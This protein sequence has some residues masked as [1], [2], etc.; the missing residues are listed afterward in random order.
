MPKDRKLDMIALL[1]AVDHH[2][3]D[4]LA[5]QSDDARKE[6]QPVVALRWAAGVSAG[7]DAGCML[8]LINHRV[9]RHLWAYQEP[10]LSFRLLASC[11]LG[12]SLRHEWLPAGRTG[13]TINAAYRLLAEHHPDANDDE[14]RVLLGTYTRAEFA[15][16]V[17]DCGK[18]KEDI[19]TCLKAYDAMRQA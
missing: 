18:T 5:A 6:F 10:D 16:F 3:G 2:D 8:W 11:G 15:E 17:A 4:W 1:R 13:G 19:K 12:K 7:S 9:N 14:L